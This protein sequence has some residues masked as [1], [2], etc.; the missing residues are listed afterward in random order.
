MQENKRG[1]FSELFPS[2]THV[3]F[4]WLPPL[5]RFDLTRVTRK[6]R[7]YGAQWRA[8][9]QVLARGLVLVFIP[10]TH[11][12]QYAHNGTHLSLVLVRVQ[13]LRCD[14]PWWPGLLTQ[15]VSG[16]LLGRTIL[17]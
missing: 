3:R 17:L 12:I 4:G 10:G 13:V 16:A 7:P 5:G 14:V 11:K 8:V 6:R 2:S 1:G 15:I 9:G